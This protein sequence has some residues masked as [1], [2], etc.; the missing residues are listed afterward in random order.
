MTNSKKAKGRP[1]GS[2]TDDSAVLNAIADMIFSNP[3]L[4]PTTAMRLLR[5]KATDAE[6]RRWQSKWKQ[7]KEALLAE[8]A[9]RAETSARRERGG[10][11]GG[12][13]NLAEM[14]ARGEL[15]DTPVM[16]AA[17]GLDLSPGMEALMEYQ[18]SPAMK[19]FREV[20]DSPAMRLL[21]QIESSGLMQRVREHHQM[22]E[23]L[24]RAGCI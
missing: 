18:N 17:R 3:V 13:N 23:R 6:I 14:I 12:R 21:R 7:R 20:Q 19:I 22:I 8:A 1:Q 9:V 5:R 15:P 4:R 10:G 2:E 16:R 24:T 11:V